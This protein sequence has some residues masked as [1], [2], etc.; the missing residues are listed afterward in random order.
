MRI[1]VSY[2][3]EFDEEAMQALTTYWGK[4][5]KRRDLK[6]LLQSYGESAIDA[7]IQEG[8]EQDG[9]RAC[10]QGWMLS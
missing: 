1:R 8:R 7:Q 10:D 5:P 9:K 6:R 4:R 3:A 2:T